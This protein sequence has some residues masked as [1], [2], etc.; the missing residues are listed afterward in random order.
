MEPKPPLRKWLLLLSLLLQSL[1]GISQVCDAPELR[2]R[3]AALYKSVDAYKPNYALSLADSLLEQLND[4]SLADCPLQGWI[5]FEKGEAFEHLW[6]YED[7]LQ[8][9]YPLVQE[10]LA[11]KRWKL[12][13]QTYISMARTHETIERSDDCRRSLQAAWEL[14]NQHKLDTVFARYAVRNASYHRWYADRDS[15]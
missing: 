11:A 1:Q 5:R 14:I 6:Q 4:L 7:A 2:L 10:A 13:A 8:I 12:A 9:Y 3:Y 15:A